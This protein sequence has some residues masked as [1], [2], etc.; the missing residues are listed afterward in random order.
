MGRLK[1]KFLVVIILF[2]ISLLISTYTYASGGIGSNQTSNEFNKN[3]QPIDSI[4]I[5]EEQQNSDFGKVPPTF[6][7]DINQNR[8]I[9]GYLFE[10]MIWSVSGG[11]LGAII[12]L[13]FQNNT[14]AKLEITA[15]EEANDEKVYPLGFVVPGKWKFFRVKVENKPVN[16]KLRWLFKR[17]PAQQVNASITITQLDKTMRGRW[18]GTLELPEENPLNRIR[19]AN[20][21]D[22]VTINPGYSEILDVFAKFESDEEAYGW[23]NKAYFN[24]WRTPDYKMIPGNYE[25]IV[26]V[27]S[28]NGAYCKRVFKA[29]IASTINNTYLTKV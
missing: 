28:E 19:L 22:P 24:K 4:N 26:E 6:V 3:N 10:N 16:K 12:A 25:I 23:N 8:N 5:G 27:T 13:L 1:I 7:K 11:F 15:S 2:F 29:H 18:A 20:F 21:P 17:Q 9:F 14:L